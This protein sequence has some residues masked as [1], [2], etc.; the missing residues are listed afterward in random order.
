MKRFHFQL[1]G[2]LANLLIFACE[3][4]AI[5][6]VP[7]LHLGEL[8]LSS[9]AV[10]VARAEMLDVAALEGGRF[11]RTTFSVERAIKGPMS[12]DDFFHIFSLSF[13][14][15][16]AFSAI[17]GD[18]RPETGKTYLLFLSNHNDAW[19]PVGLSFY[20]LEEITNAGKAY[21]PPLLNNGNIH[22]SKRPDGL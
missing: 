4:H 11:E 20:V 13:Q 10:V 9:D 2:L 18:F 6:V 5:T 8:A 14:N 22:L 15:G 16:D 21:W 1:V 7:F 3:I 17:D 19:Q 12:Q